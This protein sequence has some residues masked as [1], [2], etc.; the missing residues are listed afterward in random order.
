MCTAISFSDANGNFYFGRNLDWGSSWGERVL[1][2][3]RNFVY[4]GA[5][6][7]FDLRESGVDD[8]PGTVDEPD[9]A[10]ELGTVDKPGTDGGY[11]TIGMGIIEAGVPLYFDCANEAGLA[12]AGL[13]FPGYAQYETDALEGRCNV[14]A[15]EF[16]LWVATQFASVD[17]LE[18]ALQQ[19]AIVGA[20][21]SPRFPV[22]QLHWMI[23]D[24]KRCIVVEYTAEGMQIFSDSLRVLTNQPGFAWH[25]ENV[26]NYLNCSSEL[27][28]EVHWGETPLTAFGAGAMMHG[29]PGDYYSSS[30]FVRAAYLNSHYPSCEGEPANLVRLFRTLSGV[31]MIDGASCMSNGQ[32]EKTIYTGGYSSASQ[33]YAYECYEDL[34]LRQVRLSDFD[35]DGAELQVADV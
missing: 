5:F 24:T 31:A 20:Q 28:P 19:L 10:D 35:L 18:P 3:P 32:Y 2:T 29:I 27:A 34:S 14:A 13:N 11:A 1:V 17:E 25:K 15:Y 9:A 6:G 26:R 16:P 22:A 21:V 23:A 7:A 30:R 33:T 12:I 4:K 8:E